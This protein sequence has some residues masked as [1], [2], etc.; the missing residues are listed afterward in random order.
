[1]SPHMRRYVQIKNI[2]LTDTC[3]Y[4]CWVISKAN[5]NKKVWNITA[6]VTIKLQYK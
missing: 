6:N 5:A 1:M 2:M 3:S 4:F